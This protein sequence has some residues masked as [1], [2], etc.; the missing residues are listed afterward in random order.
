MKKALALIL[1][2]ILV[3]SLCVTVVS[4]APSKETKG[5]VTD[6][7]A[8][9]KNGNKVEV[10]LEEIDGKVNKFFYNELKELQAST[11]D[12]SLK[13]IDHYWGIVVKG[14]GKVA[15]PV[16]LTATVL[17]V[18]KYSNCYIL[19]QKGNKVISVKPT[20]KDDKLIF[21]VDK[22]YDQLALVA[23]GKTAKNVEDE[24]NVLS[25]Q[26]ADVTPIAIVLATLSLIGIAVLPKKIKEN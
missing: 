17:G 8:V 12:K 14:E 11:G 5:V 18:S 25:P 20:V 16:K 24:N 22:N 26:T 6:I 9:D 19:L 2:V 13:I 10:Y 4:A 23:D 7:E 15:W 21:S 3:V 1:T